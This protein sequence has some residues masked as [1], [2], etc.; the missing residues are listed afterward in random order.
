MSTLVVDTLTNQEPQLCKAWVNFNGTGAVAIRAAYNVS[1]ITDNATGDYT[2]NFT[3]TMPDA[4]Y[5]V[6]GTREWQDNFNGNV[7]TI[8]IRDGYTPLSTS[9][10]VVSVNGNF[11]AGG[12]SDCDYGYVTIFR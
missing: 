6:I 8:S 1:S 5:T 11:S 7:S 2:I 3:N 10:R 4:N 12:L 9:V